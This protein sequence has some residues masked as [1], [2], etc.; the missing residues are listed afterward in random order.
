MLELTENNNDNETWSGKINA[1]NTLLRE[2]QS[3]IVQESNQINARINGE[4]KSLDGK[5]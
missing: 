5:I 4:F 2:T 3:V 1:T